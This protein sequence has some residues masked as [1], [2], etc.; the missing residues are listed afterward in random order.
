[1][2]DIWIPSLPR[3]NLGLAGG[4]YDDWSAPKVLWHTTEGGSVLG[5]RKAFAPYPPHLCYDPNT[6]QGEQYIPLNR[7]SYSLRKSESDDEYCIQVELVGYASQT[8]LWSDTLLRAIAQDIVRPLRE[9]AGV[10]DVVVWK[11]FH[12]ERDGIVLASTKSPIRLTDAELRAFSGHLGHQHAPGSGTDGDEHWDPG[13]LPMGK[14]LAYS[15]EGATM[16]LTNTDADV[17]LN[18]TRTR[19]DDPSLNSSLSG[20]IAYYDEHRIAAQNHRNNIQATQ[21]AHGQVL[22][23]IREAV[24]APSDAP[25]AAAATEVAVTDEQLAKALADPAVASA[26]AKAYADEQDKRAR[27]GNAATGPAS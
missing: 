5:A 27:D 11:G 24:R 26:W 22:A 21:A 14:I 8:H 4:P 7:H 1:M 15:Q 6:R 17:V 13:A 12:G 2:P 25:A 9:L 23:E 18:R 19:H 20:I 10:P 3:V 16:A